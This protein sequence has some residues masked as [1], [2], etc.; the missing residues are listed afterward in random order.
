[1]NKTPKKFK[2]PPKKYHPKGLTILYEDHDILVADKVCGLPL[3]SPDKE[4]LRTAQLLLNDYV[5]KGNPKSRKQVFLAH[6]LDKEASGILVVTKHE[7]AKLFFQKEWK[8]FRSKQMAVVLGAMPEPQGEITTY[9][10]E[11]SALRVYATTNSEE[12]KYA[13][14]GYRVVRE[15]ETCSLLEI[16]QFTAHKEQTRVHLAFKGCPV[17]GDKKYGEKAPGIKRLTLH[18]SSITLVH[19]FTKEK[20]TFTAKVPPYF[21]YLMRNGPDLIEI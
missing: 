8:N 15:S 21:N 14:T 5:C 11:N 20:M 10:A 7:E 2:S 17:L 12:G 4:E 19:P 13:K 1:M 3:S 6:R 9:L 16:D 18:A